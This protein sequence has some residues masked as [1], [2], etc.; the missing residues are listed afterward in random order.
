MSAAATKGK[1]KGVL[2]PSQIFMK[3]MVGRKG[4][5]VLNI[6]S[7]NAYTP[8]TKIP[9]YLFYPYSNSDYVPKITNVIF[10]EGSH[11]TSIGSSAFSGCTDLTSITIPNSVTSIGFYT[12]Y[13]CKSL[14]GI[15]VPNSV[16]YIGDAAFGNC[17]GL[18]SMT[19]PFIGYSRGKT[20]TKNATLGYIFGES[21]ESATAIH[22]LATQRYLNDYGYEKTFTFKMEVFTFCTKIRC[23]GDALRGSFCVK[24]K[25]TSQKCEVF[26][27]CFYKRRL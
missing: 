8:L 13:N 6:S 15:V 24:S 27:V 22:Y 3:D 23:F 1:L 11:I 5:S 4:C 19:L 16:Q 10:E 17:T 12:F 21:S 20:T 9:A 14:K 7:M 2:L 26:W 18:K 25:N